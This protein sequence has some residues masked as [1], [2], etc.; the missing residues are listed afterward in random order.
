MLKKFTRLKKLQDCFS[1]R[2]KIAWFVIPLIALRKLKACDGLYIHSKNVLKGAN[3]AR[4]A[5]RKGTQVR[6]L[7][8]ERHKG[9]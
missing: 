5:R 2:I 8:S 4:K 7:K 6:Q 9:M 3:K 1:T